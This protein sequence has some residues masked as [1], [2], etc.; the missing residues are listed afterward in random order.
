MCTAHLDEG[1]DDEKGMELCSSAGVRPHASHDCARRLAAVHP[2][3]VFAFFFPALHVLHFVYSHRCPAA[4]TLHESDPC[5]RV[6][7]AADADDMRQGA[8][9]VDV[10]V[11]AER[12]D[13]IPGW[14]WGTVRMAEQEAR[15][16]L[17]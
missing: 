3:L 9:D 11:V 4:R 5:E 13:E 2:Q 7:H 15:P 17:T 16:T 14:E 6:K 12:K 8:N 10:G 1:G